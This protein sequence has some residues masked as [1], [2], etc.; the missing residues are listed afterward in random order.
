MKTTRFSQSTF[1]EVSFRMGRGTLRRPLPACRR[2]RT[3]VSALWPPLPPGEGWGEGEGEKT[4]TVGRCCYGNC[5]KEAPGG[6]TLRTSYVPQRESDATRAVVLGT[7]MSY[8]PTGRRLA[9]AL[10]PTLSRRE[11]EPEGA[12]QDPD[13][14]HPAG[15]ANFVSPPRGKGTPQ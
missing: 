6:G 14:K 5:R 13:P 10:T 8:A 3:P 12:R 1:V 15:R 11:R 2:A 7:A 9:F 4:Q